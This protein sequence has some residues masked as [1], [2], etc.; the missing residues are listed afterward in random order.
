MLADSSDGWA[1]QED[2]EEQDED[3]AGEDG[4]DPMEDSE[5]RE[6]P[7]GSA[8]STEVRRLRTLS[9]LQWASHALVFVP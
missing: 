7:D 5:W 8:L 3:D 4:C 2:S 9:C 1:D 6:D